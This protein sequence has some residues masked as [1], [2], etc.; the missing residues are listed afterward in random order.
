MRDIWRLTGE[1][2][3][4]FW[5]EVE[6]QDLD[7]EH[8]VGTEITVAPGRTLIVHKAYVDIARIIMDI[9]D[10]RPLD[11]PGLQAL[12]RGSPGVGK[13][14]F[15]LFFLACLK[16]KLK[17]DLEHKTNEEDGWTI[18]YEDNTS[19]LY[20]RIIELTAGPGETFRAESVPSAKRDE[21]IF[22]LERGR[23]NWLLLDG[24]E[25]KDFRFWKG[26][27]LLAA[28]SRKDNYNEYKKYASVDLVMPIWTSGEIDAL[29]ESSKG[30]TGLDQSDE[31][32]EIR[33]YAGGI[34]RDYLPLLKGVNPL[35][36]LRTAASRALQ[37]LKLN[38]IR[39]W[40]GEGPRGIPADD[41]PASALLSLDCSRD[42]YSYSDAKIVWRS[43]F[44][45]MQWAL[46]L[47]KGQLR[48]ELDFVEDP[49]PGGQQKGKI[50]ESL[51][52]V[53]LACTRNPISLEPI[54]K[55]QERVRNIPRAERMYEGQESTQKPHFLRTLTL[56][57][58]KLPKRE[59]RVFLGNDAKTYD[60]VYEEGFWVPSSEKDIDSLY[61]EGDTVY[62]FRATTDTNHE[63]SGFNE[64]LIRR[65]RCGKAM[66]FSKTPF[67]IVW[68]IPQGEEIRPKWPKDKLG[69]FL[70]DKDKFEEYVFELPTERAMEELSEYMGRPAA[71]KKGARAGILSWITRSYFENEK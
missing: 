63:A 65:L 26:P 27:A 17:K 33:M 14:Y 4:R 69:E 52:N 36:E 38:D 59:A 57:G 48:S 53:F 68:C 31:L 22:S 30:T 6:P 46:T 50:F 55:H 61:V 23:R 70:P 56:E 25:G 47:S 20:S 67:V 7:K 9:A 60:N 19:R 16:H 35:P 24:W 10:K 54:K 44:I 13:S 39:R 40:T 64:D 5:E 18:V 15:L 41:I 71:L 12:L 62:L 37:G 45:G 21:V 66:K 8:L 2:L 49:T 29:L 32:D 28:S 42:D 34:V 3:E 51:V 1:Q 11:V 58:S 43:S